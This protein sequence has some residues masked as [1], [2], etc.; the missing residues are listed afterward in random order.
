MAVDV[1]AAGRR[2]NPPEPGVPALCAFSPLHYLELPELLM[3]FISSMTGKSPSTTGAGSEGA[4][5]KAPFNALPTTYDLN[6]AFLSYALTGYDGWVSG[7]GSRRPDRRVDHDVSLLIPE[8]FARMPRTSGPRVAHR[9]RLSR[10]GRGC[11]DRRARGPG[12]P[13]GA[14]GSP[15]SSRRTFL[16]RIFMHPD[17]IFTEAILRP[18][19]QDLA[20]FAESVEVM[21]AT[22]E[23]VAQAYVEDGTIASACPPVRALLEIMASGASQEGWTLQS[24]EFRAL[25]TRDS[26]LASPWYAARLDAAQAQEVAR[27]DAG[28]A[29]LSAFLAADGPSGAADRLEVRA[30]LDAVRAAR[31]EAASATA[32]EALVGTLGRQA[33]FR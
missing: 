7:A 23:R 14:T 16:G 5:T 18:E 20:V 6:A 26:V 17:A 28:I 15:R 29:Q 31:D 2:N 30:R 33:R 10:A 4:M 9:E 21:V 24:P 3:E 11:R 13:A 22:H 8:I 12:E 32:R 27:A 25:F 19:T 1:V